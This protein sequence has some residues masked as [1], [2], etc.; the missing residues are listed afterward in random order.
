METTGQQVITHELHY[1][2]TE[3]EPDSKGLQAGQKR[4]LASSPAVSASADSAAGYSSNRQSRTE[5]EGQ[6]NNTAGPYECKANSRCTY[7]VE[8]GNWVHPPHYS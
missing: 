8:P 1:H 7:T 4:S 3:F 6:E 5:P 2:S